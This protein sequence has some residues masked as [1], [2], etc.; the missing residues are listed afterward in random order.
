M[1][2]AQER[3]G[4]IEE[5]ADA[6]ANLPRRPASAPRILS[7]C[8]LYP[9]PAYPA[10]GVFVQRRLRHLAELAEVQVAAPIGILQ[11]GRPR[12]KRLCPGKDI[13]PTERWDG[14]VR[15]VQPRWFYPPFSGS[16]SGFW[17]YLQ[18][19]YPLARLRRAFPFD[20]LDTHFGHP[21]GVAG[22]LLSRAFGVPFTMTL[23]GNEPKH[24]RT[25]WERCWMGWAIRRAS[26]VITVSERLRQFAIG[27]GAK[28]ANVKTIPNG[29]DA[30]LFRPR[31]R[32]RC[33]RKY[34][35]ASDR[36]TIVSVGALVERKGHHR[37]IRALHAILREG[38]DIELA[39]AGGPGPEGQYERELRGLVSE[40]RLQDRVKFLG[41][42]P[43]DSLAEV[44]SA[45][46]VLCLASTNEGWPNVIHEALACGTPVVAT[47]VGAV[48][49]M[50]DGGRFGIIVP[51]NRQ[52]ELEQA[53]AAALDC[54]WDRTAIAEWGQR[55]SWRH[56]ADE[57]FEEMCGVAALKSKRA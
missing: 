54:N 45:A 5:G 19:L 31:D 56:V 50:L 42:L 47:D 21:E 1:N 10:Q 37:A 22:C 35:F 55:R 15:V 27:L 38:K 11:Y 40:L 51:V 14:G 48:P 25:F 2:R 52:P 9:N 41:S 32:E 24:S 23:R 16:F 6:C 43:A 4:E 30:D 33:R 3:P 12:G 39:I 17:L 8:C 53:L 44:L 49:E 57:V 46:D 13:C 7:L 20:V 34:D 18:L 26:R 28:P 29:V 36:R